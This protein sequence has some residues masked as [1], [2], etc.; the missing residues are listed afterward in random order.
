MYEYTYLFTVMSNVYIGTRIR[1]I[2]LHDFKHKKQQNRYNLPLFL[3]ESVGNVLE[4]GTQE[5]KRFILKNL[6]E[7]Y[8]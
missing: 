2:P 4:H 7:G 6:F 1:S 5:N 8:F 3:R